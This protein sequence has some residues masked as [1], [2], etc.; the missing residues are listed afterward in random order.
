MAK[1]AA[2]NKL[3]KVIKTKSKCEKL[4][5]RLTML[6]DRVSKHRAELTASKL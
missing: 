2:E 5:K 4:Q 1:L 6:R 3:L